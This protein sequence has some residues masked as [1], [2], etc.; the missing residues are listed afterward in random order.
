MVYRKSLEQNR[1]FV[2]I[3][4]KYHLDPQRIGNPTPELAITM[5]DALLDIGYQNLT[6]GPNLRVLKK[7]FGANL[8]KFDCDEASKEARRIK[9]ALVSGYLRAK[10]ELESAALDEASKT[11]NPESKKTGIRKRLDKQD[12][13]EFLFRGFGGS[14]EKSLDDK[15]SGEY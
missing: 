7:R 8:K 1:Q 10:R 14:D 12:Q 13:E 5:I 9:H 4:E 2:D 6:S 3:V 15:I 11:Q